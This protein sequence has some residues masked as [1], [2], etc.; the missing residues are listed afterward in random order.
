MTQQ[1]CKTFLIVPA[2][3]AL[4][5]TLP[6]IVQCGSAQ[7]IGTKWKMLLSAKNPLITYFYQ[8]RYLLIHVSGLSVV[9]IRLFLF[10]YTVLQT[11]LNCVFPKTKWA[12]SQTK[13]VVNFQ[14]C[15]T[16]LFWGKN[17]KHRKFKMSDCNKI[18]TAGRNLK[19]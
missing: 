3:W 14:I 10:H 18:V 16:Y 12:L 7:H 1:L 8:K 9:Q 17:T 11:Y 15:H 2:A 19:F 13:S 5:Q 6:C 4:Q